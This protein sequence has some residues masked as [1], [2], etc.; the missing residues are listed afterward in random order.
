MAL[1]TILSALKFPLAVSWAYSLVVG[2]LLPSL[3]L[4][5]WVPAATSAHLSWVLGLMTMAGHLGQ[6]LLVLELLFVLHHLLVARQVPSS[7]GL[8]P[9]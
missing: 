7:E 9:R 5:A 3:G 4:K 8:V 2:L 1:A 6:A